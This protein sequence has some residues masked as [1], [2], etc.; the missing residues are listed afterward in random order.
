MILIRLEMFSTY[1]V[2]SKFQLKSIAVVISFE[3]NCHFTLFCLSDQ[4]FWKEMN[5]I[6]ERFKEH[7]LYLFIFSFDQT[8][9]FL[10]LFLFVCL[11]FVNAEEKL[12]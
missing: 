3:G 6:F 1:E 7:K 11:F 10:F 8:S 2:I 4:Y 5:Y 9:F 12:I